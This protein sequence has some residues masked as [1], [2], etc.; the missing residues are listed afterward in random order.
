MTGTVV[1]SGE[2]ITSAFPVYEGTINKHAVK[3]IPFGGRDITDYIK[4]QLALEPD[5][6]INM[7][8]YG[9]NQVFRRMKQELCYCGEPR[10]VPETEYKLPDGETICVSDVEETFPF[11]APEFF[12]FDPGRLDW[13][14]DSTGIS[15]ESVQQMIFK[16]LMDCS[17]DT[18]KKLTENIILC[19]SNTLFDG[20]PE[21]MYKKLKT[22][23]T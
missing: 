15:E 23:V 2:C 16:S 7:S 12:F 20:L 6:E 1:D 19:G 13:D 18:R 10:D 22:E 21:M 17:I 4:K 9:Q 3:S 14:E 5:H 11:R 8:H